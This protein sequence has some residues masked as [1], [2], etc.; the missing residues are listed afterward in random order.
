MENKKN[1]KNLI[2]APHIDDEVLGCF[3]AIGKDT[4]I[5]YCGYDESHINFNWVKSRPNSTER[6]EEL[7]RL[8]EEYG[9]S[10]DLLYNKVNYY[11]IQDLIPCFEDAINKIK[12]EYLYIPVPSYNQDHRMV[13]EACLTALRPHDVNFFVKKVL[14]YEQIQDLWNHNYHDFKPTFFKKLDI[15]DKIK[16]YQIVARGQIFQK[17]RDASQSSFC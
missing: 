16:G 15:E 10:Y 4:F 8:G 13:Y 12:P 1:F 3:S 7:Q 5:L 6:L 9:F 14:L 11:S 17:P 2:I